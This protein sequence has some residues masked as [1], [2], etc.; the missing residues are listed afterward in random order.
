MEQKI[1]LD[2][3]ILV[4]I[5]K[6]ESSPALEKIE[7]KQIAISSI[8]SFELYQR[9]TNLRDIEKLLF[10]ID[11]LPFNF[12]ASKIASDIFKDLRKRGKIIDFRDIF[13]ASV[14]IANDYKLYTLNKKHFER[15]NGLR[16]F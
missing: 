11:V 1:C 4:D 5:L 10:N 16:L 6:D 15:I 12:K 8:T 2:T 13:I 7:N 14:A 9:E 3:N